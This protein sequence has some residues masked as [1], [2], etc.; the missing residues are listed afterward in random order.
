MNLFALLLLS[1]LGL[2]WTYQNNQ[3]TLHTIDGLSVRY[4]KDA[5]EESLLWHKEIE[6]L[7]KKFP[8]LKKL[9]T[10]I[11]NDF[12]EALWIEQGAQKPLLILT[13]GIHGAEA[14][15]G[16]ALQRLFMQHL[17]RTSSLKANVLL[18]HALNP[19][20]FKTFRR[21]N[22]KN[23]DLNRN[24]YGPNESQNENHAYQKMRDLLEPQGPASASL[25]SRWWFFLRV[26]WFS[27]WNGKKEVLGVLSGQHQAPRGIYF[28]GEKAQEETLSVQKWIRDFGA[29]A[30]VILHIDL[31]T[32]FGER[33]KLHFYGSEEFSSDEQKRWLKKIFPTQSVDT[34]QSADFYATHGDLIDWTWKQLSSQNVIPMVFEFG[35]MNSQTLTGGLLSLWTSVLENQGHQFGYASPQDEK[36]TQKLF[37][38]LF[39]PQDVNWQKSVLTQGL[40]AL[41][42]SLQQ[43]ET[44]SQN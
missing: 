36:S 10:P 23:I 17:E 37:E 44:Q 7:Q 27:L 30:P 32:G 11:E 2:A 39:N 24:F 42:M 33:G 21:T 25:I 34:A 22:A 40:S 38:K 8:Q 1:S 29:Q 13:S 19:H 14:F 4:A 6:A 16:T 18:I 15:T 43:L 20:G 26:A 9:V 31:H 28:S 12:I 5:A 35:T 41:T 3:T